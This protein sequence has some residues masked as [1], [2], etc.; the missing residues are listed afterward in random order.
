MTLCL[1]HTPF[2]KYTVRGG[3]R[4]YYISEGEHFE[5]NEDEERKKR[6]ELKRMAI[7]SLQRKN[8][9]HYFHFANDCS[10]IKAMSNIL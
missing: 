2:D 1:G 9:I 8:R 7:A 5:G 3:L 6:Q 4:L 10:I